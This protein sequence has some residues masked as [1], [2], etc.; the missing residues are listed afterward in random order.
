M[1]RFVPAAIALFALSA[2][3]LAA[4]PTVTETLADDARLNAVAAFNAARAWAVGDRGVVRRTVDG[5][6]TWSPRETPTD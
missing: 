6:E 5:G 4:A 3:P 1:R 2:C